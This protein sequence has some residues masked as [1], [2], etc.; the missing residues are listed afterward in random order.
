MIPHI[1]GV[2]IKGS[3]YHLLCQNADDSAMTLGDDQ[4]SI[5]PALNIL[6]C[7]S[8]CVGLQVNFD[9]IKTY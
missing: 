9:K 2:T 6:D 1:S 4:N 3:V 5:Q 7:F 8:V